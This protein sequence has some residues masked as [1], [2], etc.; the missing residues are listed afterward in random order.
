MSSPEVVRLADGSDLRGLA[1]EWRRL[2]RRVDGA[3]YFQ[4]PDWVLS[5]WESLGEHAPT[6]VTTWR[7]ANGSLEG[8]ATLSRVE[9]RFHARLPLRLPIWINTESAAG[10]ADH[11]GWPVLPERVPEVRQWLATRM[12]SAPL[13]LRNLDPQSGVPF[14]IPGARLLQKS[15]CPRVEIPSGTSGRGPA[16]PAGRTRR[17]AQELE[18]AGVHFR[19]VPPDRMEPSILEPLF[20][21]H[22]ERM[23]AKGWP[24][25]V[26]PHEQDF[27]RRLIA[28]AAPG[29]GPAA[30]LAE[31]DGRTIGVEYGFLWRDTFA[32]YKNGWD[33]AWAHVRLGNVLLRETIR[34]LA[35]QGVRVFDLLRGKEAYK[36]EFHPVERRDETWFLPNGPTGRI[37]A[38]RESALHLVHRD[39]GFY[40]W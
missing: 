38:M 10:E 11:C 33:P 40:L 19:W 21:F 7:D 39:P 18:T 31:L 17:R 26:D 5:W 4:T 29:C 1:D 35:Q 23:R 8:V 22:R 16:P 20:R 28:L 13:L 36:Y 25:T 32:G 24:L 9:E 27:H 15:V 34:S 6:E 3:S 2:A 30:L 37:L 14:V 12:K